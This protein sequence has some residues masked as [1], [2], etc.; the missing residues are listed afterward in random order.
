MV[1]AQTATIRKLTVE[2]RANN[3]SLQQ[4]KAQLLIHRPELVAAK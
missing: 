3:K 1:Q 4:V 2:V